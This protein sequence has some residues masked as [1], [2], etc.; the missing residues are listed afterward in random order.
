LF[1]IDLEPKESNK[2]IYE[3]K[4]LR[5]IKITVEAKRKKNDIVQYTRRQWYGHTKA[6]C[7]TP[8]TCV[9]C[10]GEHN[11]T[12]CKENPNTPGKW[13]LR[14]GNHPA[15]YK[16]CDIYKNLEK[17]RSKTTIQPRRNSTQSQNTSININSKNQF[18]P[19]NP[20][21][22]PVPISAN[23]QATYSQILLQNQHSPNISKQ[24]S[25]FLNEFKAMFSQLINRNGMV[26]NMLSTIINKII[27]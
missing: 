13:A 12:S 24:L 17:A 19:L 11:T 4:Y 23:Q 15:N 20:N 21:Q 1:F 9:K 2:S 22:P 6:Y 27:H 10:G 3:I 18:P 8:Y 26:L 16:G 25:T 5:N 14:G 7:V